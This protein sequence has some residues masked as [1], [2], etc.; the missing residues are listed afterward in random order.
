MVSKPYV[1]SQGQANDGLQLESEAVSVW[2]P[3]WYD[4]LGFCKFPLG[5]ACV[6][7]ADLPIGTWNALGQRLSEEKILHA[8]E[9]LSKS[10]IRIANL[11]IDD[12]WQSLD[13]GHDQSQ[14]GWAEFEA[15]R[16]AFPNGLRG[17]VAQVRQLHPDIKNIMVWHALLGYWGGISPKG[18]IAKTYTT[19]NVTQEEGSR[20]V[21]TVVDKSDVPRFY[22]DFYN[23]L[24]ESGIDGVKA[25]AQVMIEQLQT[26]PDRRDLIST[27]LDAWSAAA[28]RYFG[29]KTISCMSQFPQAIF[30][31]QLP[32]SRQEM[33]VRNSDDFFPD[34]PRSHPWHVWANAHNAILTQ[35]LNAVPDWDMFQTAHDY[36][37]FHAAARCVS[38]GPIYITDVPGKHNLQL[39]R[40]ITATTPLGQTIIL[41]PSV[42]GRSIYAYAGYEED[43]LLKIGSFNGKA[44]L[45][46]ICF[47]V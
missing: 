15:D 25:D 41:R 43:S 14:R 6:L 17:L 3:E 31:S 21:L 30:H 7:D 36:S 35:F 28:Q 19:T 46:C 13:D 20:H 11:V 22:D 44:Q 8:V 18:L 37:E 23:F 39:I 4:G 33:L 38:G 26:A 24:A 1:V 47:A 10:K 34:I 9:E 12:N 42:L 16:M 27:Y 32:R 45:S 5:I 40:Q 2:K 29:V